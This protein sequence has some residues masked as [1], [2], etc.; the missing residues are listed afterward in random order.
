MDDEVDIGELFTRLPGWQWVLPRVEIDGS[1]TLRDRAVDRETH[2]WGMSQPIDSGPALPPRL[3]DVLLVPGL[4]F[5]ESGGRLGRGG[6]HY[7]RLISDCRP[8]C[9]IVGV[10]WEERVVAAVPMEPH[11]R[12]VGWLATGTGVRECAPTR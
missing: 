11:D 2:R 8:D 9:A 10:T 12:R 4:A 7:D 6:G 3:L 1:L 5:D